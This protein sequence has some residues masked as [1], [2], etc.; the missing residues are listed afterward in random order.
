MLRLQNCEHRINFRLW[1]QIFTQT[2]HQSKQSV[3]PLIDNTELANSQAEAF[4]IA[5]AS[6]AQLEDGV[7]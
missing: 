3:R 2:E 5:N 7:Q 4:I 1:F 6:V